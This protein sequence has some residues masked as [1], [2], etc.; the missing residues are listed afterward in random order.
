[1]AK[2]HAPNTMLR[3]I[4]CTCDLSPSAETLCR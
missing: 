1:M 3:L 2:T 4:C